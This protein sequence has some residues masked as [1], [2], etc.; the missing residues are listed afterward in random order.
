MPW[1][2][3]FAGSLNTLCLLAHQRWRH[4]DASGE[5]LSSLIHP[6]YAA[7][8][9]ERSFLPHRLGNWEVPDSCK[10]EGTSQKNR[11][12]RTS[13]RTSSTTLIAST[14]GHLDPNHRRPGVTAFTTTNELQRPIYAVSKPR[15]PEVQH[16][17]SMCMLY[18]QIFQPCCT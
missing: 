8:Q 5:N 18:C 15:W 2:G 1:Q 9:Y 12:D 3:K 13:P 4:S 16:M 14:N 11:F 17:F 10:L 7:S 6:H